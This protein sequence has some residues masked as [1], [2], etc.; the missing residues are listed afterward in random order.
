MSKSNIELKKRIRELEKL[1]ENLVTSMGNQKDFY[2]C[3]MALVEAVKKNKG[4]M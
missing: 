4:E 3:L 2:H 1:I